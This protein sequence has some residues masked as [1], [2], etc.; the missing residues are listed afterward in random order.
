MLEIYR[1]EIDKIDKEI[2]SLYEKRLEVCRNI[3]NYKKQNNMDIYN[4]E[5]ENIVIKNC[6]DNIINYEN[7][8][9][10]VNLIKF[11]M[12]ESKVLQEKM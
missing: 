6:L 11:I 2:I 12:S 1:D 10:V 9:Y 8:D 4:K 5:R 7:K 3:S